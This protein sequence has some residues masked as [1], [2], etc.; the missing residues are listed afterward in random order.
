MR[1]LLMHYESPL[2][3]AKLP[4]TVYLAGV[5]TPGNWALTCREHV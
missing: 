5:F 4:E 3:Q 2:R 1:V